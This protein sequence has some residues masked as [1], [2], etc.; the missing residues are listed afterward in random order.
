VVKYPPNSV[1]D[2][3]TRTESHPTAISI[4]DS[5]LHHVDAGTTLVWN[6]GKSKLQ[7]SDNFWIKSS[8][9]WEVKPDRTVILPPDA[10]RLVRGSSWGT[11]TIGCTIPIALLVGLWMYKIRPG[12][13]VVASIIV[14]CLMLVATV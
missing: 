5:T 13:V 12:R 10:V 2:L 6:G 8:G 3:N 14:A 1:L 9:E 11:F 4:A 7:L